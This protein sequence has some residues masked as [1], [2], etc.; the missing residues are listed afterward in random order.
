M[1]LK[2][3]RLEGESLYCEFGNR[4][5]IFL[6]KYKV[7]TN[8]GALRISGEF[9]EEASFPY[10]IREEEEPTLFNR[11]S[12]SYV[13]FRTRGML[14]WKKEEFVIPARHLVRLK[15]V[16]VSFTSSDWSVEGVIY[17][18]AFGTAI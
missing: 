12:Y 14:W 6:P 3:K 8:Q 4:N 2:L 1:E 5:G 18:T 10:D 16:F 7:T 15:P 9:V 11:V 13:K 17:D